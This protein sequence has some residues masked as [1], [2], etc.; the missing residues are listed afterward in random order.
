MLIPKLQPDFFCS[1][2]SPPDQPNSPDELQ[3]DL[4]AAPKAEFKTS[5]RPGATKL[6]AR[7]TVTFD[8]LQIL[9]CCVL[10]YGHNTLGPERPSELPGRTE[11]VHS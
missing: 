10:F 7:V 4:P 8:S 9:L 5:V 6:V 3:S 2:A 11:I 1:T